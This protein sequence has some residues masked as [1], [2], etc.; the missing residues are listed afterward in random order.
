M[1][2]HEEAAG[3]M[4]QRSLRRR[5][6]SRFGCRLRLQLWPIN[7]ILPAPQRLNKPS[8]AR[9]WTQFRFICSLAVADTTLLLL[10]FLCARR[11]SLLEM[12]HHDSRHGGTGS[13]QAADEQA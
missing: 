9:L 4:F 10:P 13:T 7:G 2:T 8:Q 12:V 1:G 3:R 6:C 5:H 11:A